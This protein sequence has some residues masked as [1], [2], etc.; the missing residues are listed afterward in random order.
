MTPGDSRPGWV[1]SD[2]FAPLHP[3]VGKP[4]AEQIGQN[5]QRGLVD[6]AKHY[7]RSHGLNF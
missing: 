3:P 6:G 1:Q 4:S 5:S 7:S 2:V